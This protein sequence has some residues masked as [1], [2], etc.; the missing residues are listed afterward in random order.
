MKALLLFF[1]SVAAQGATCELGLP[2]VHENSAGRFLAQWDFKSAGI[3]SEKELPVAPELAAYQQKVKQLIPDTNPYKLLARYAARGPAADD[4]FNLEVVQ[5]KEAGVMHNLTCI[6]ALLLDYQ[7]QRNPLM[8][9]RPTEFVAYFLRRQG[10]ARVYF[11]TNDAEGV[12]GMAELYARVKMDESND[13]SV[14]GNLHN[15]SFFLGDVSGPG[16]QGVLAPSAS[17]VKLLR[18]AVE[19][20][21]LTAAYITNG[22]QTVRIKGA[23]LKLFRAAD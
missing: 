9:E 2:Q 12:S 17:D 13:W 23:D 19:E 7:L 20:V 1:V 8:A 10:G 5:R 4:L 16:P 15:H 3:L 18:A 6:E 14:V 21:D 11:F 22:F